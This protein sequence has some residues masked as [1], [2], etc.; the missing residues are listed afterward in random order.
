MVTNNS[1]VCTVP[2]FREDRS[3]TEKGVSLKGKG[4]ESPVTKDRSSQSKKGLKKT[5][6]PPD[7]P[8]AFHKDEGS[9][10]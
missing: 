2:M 8:T 3:Q 9:R 1:E 10:S 5:D 6:R 4:W 7:N